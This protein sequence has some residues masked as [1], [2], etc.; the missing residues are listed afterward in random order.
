M[1]NVCSEPLRTRRLRSAFLLP[2]TLAALGGSFGLAVPLAAQAAAE[3]ETVNFEGVASLDRRIVQRSVHTRASR[4]RSPLFLLPCRIGD[5]GWAEFT[6]YLDTA[7]VRR[8]EERIATLYEA[9]GYP[10]A[11]VKSTISP[12]SDGDVTVTYQITEGQPI[13]I[14]DLTVR[15]LDSIVDLELPALPLKKSE[16]YALPR[17]QDTQELLQKLLAQR[18]YPLAEVEISGDLDPITRQAGIILEVKP[19][20]RAFFGGTRVRADPPVGE[21]VVRKRIAFDP[22]DAFSLDAIER[23]ERNL[24]ALPIVQRAVAEPSRSPSGDSLIDV[25]ITVNSRKPHGFSGEALVSSTDCAEMRGFWQHRYFLGGPRVFALGATASNLFAQQTAGDFPCSS[26]GTGAYG[27]PNFD[28]EAD[29]RQFIGRNQMLIVRAYAERESAPSVYV[30]KGFGGELALARSFTPKLD[31]MLGVSPE[32]NR[33]NAAQLYFCGQYGV[34]TSSGVASLSSAKWLTP[35]ELLGVWNSTDAPP[36]VRPPDP[37][38]GRDW[39]DGV[40]PTQRW[41]VRGAVSTADSYTGSDYAYRRAMLEVRTTRT[42]GGR[43]ELA[44]R[45]RAGALDADGI[46]PPQVLFFSGGASTVRGNEQNLL[47]PKILVA[48][49][50]PTAD[51]TLDPERV[52]LRPTGGHRVLDGNLEARLWLGSRLQ[53]AAF[54]DGGRVS[55]S[56][57][58]GLASHSESNLTPGIGLRVIGDLGPI[59]IDLGYDP[60]GRKQYP[61][62]LQEANGDVRFLRNAIY[63]PYTYDRPGFFTELVRRFQIHLAVGQPF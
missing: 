49:E 62:F 21:S 47:G 37:G 38:P 30:Q 43:L 58:G 48:R 12:R 61:L 13:L 18:G 20:R 41:S 46:L 6:T 56:D 35:V 54:L 57:I 32:R 36:D 19:G 60:S 1:R 7:E 11:V 59:R 55:R 15:G 33:L 3:I 28:V 44:G 42:I 27:K 29:L 10:D 24:Y 45:L 63:D 14:R 16:P 34:C 53:I 50:E 26:A 2:G 31:V 40:I 25:L 8:D 17:L 22:G 51:G 4:C 39:V 9:W 5:Y 52:S 23:T